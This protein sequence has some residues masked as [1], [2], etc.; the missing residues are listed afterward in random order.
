MLHF[1]PP[2]DEHLVRIFNTAFLRALTGSPPDGTQTNIA[3]LIR[4]PEFEALLGAIQEL[5]H[6]TGQPED[7]AATGLVNLFRQ[8]EAIWTAYLIR[9]GLERV[10]GSA[11]PT[12]A[13]PTFEG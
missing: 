7:A 2:T 3:H 10:K 12:F 11:N 1:R 8:L 4:T 5:A 9:Q 6:R 13:N